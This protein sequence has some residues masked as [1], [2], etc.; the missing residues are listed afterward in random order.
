MLGGFSALARV[1]HRSW[2]APGAFFFLFWTILVI[3]SF[4]LPQFSPWPGTVW[5]I[6]AT[7]VVFYLGGLAGEAVAWPK[8]LRVNRRLPVRRLMLFRPAV[9]IIICFIAGMSYTVLCQLL[10]VNFRTVEPPLTLQFLL[11]FHFAGPCIGGMIYSSKSLSSRRAWLTLLPLI[12]PALLALLFTGRMAIWFPILSWI[13]GYFAFQVL[14]KRGNIPVFNRKN[15]LRG[16]AVVS[17]GLFL[18][19]GIYM[20]RIFRGSES[21]FEEKLN[22]YVDAKDSENAFADS[23]NKLKPAVFG[24]VYSFS[25]YFTD[26]LRSRPSPQWGAFSFAG[27]IG[28]FGLGRGRVSSQ[29]FEIDE[30]VWSNTYTMLRSPITDFGFWGS[31]LW[32]LMV[33]AGVGYAYARVRRGRLFSALFLV[34]FYADMMT[35]GGYFFRYNSVILS[36]VIVGLYLFLSRPRSSGLRAPA[37]GHIR[38]SSHRQEAKGPGG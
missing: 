29:S 21:G 34:W 37:F 22:A 2:S 6:L 4:L 16:V 9:T 15:L 1:T 5:W 28:L 17:L 27:P 25:F 31:L 26:T 3:V 19:T 14:I 36:Y 13:A 12:P 24:Q 11:P 20:L 33:G 8:T 18:G 23:W 32:W 7:C 30:G 35:L 10:G 38:A